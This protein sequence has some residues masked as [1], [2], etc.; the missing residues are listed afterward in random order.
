MIILNHKL[1]IFMMDKDNDGRDLSDL[2]TKAKKLLTSAFGGLT[3]TKAEGLWFDDER[4][5]TDESHIFTCNYSGK[6][7]DTQKTAFL[8][9]IKDELSKGRQAAVSI[10]LDDTLCILDG[11]DLDELKDILATR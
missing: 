3:I 1:S 10:M 11:S 9:V 6:L 8:N 4:L 5:Y 2:N 7:Y